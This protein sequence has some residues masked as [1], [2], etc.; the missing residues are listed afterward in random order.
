MGQKRPV[1]IR[2]DNR[3]ITQ[4]EGECNQNLNLNSNKI[5]FAMCIFF[6]VCFL[7]FSRI[8]NTFIFATLQKRKTFYFGVLLLYQPSLIYNFYCLWILRAWSKLH[9]VSISNWMSHLSACRPH[10]CCASMIT[11]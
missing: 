1:N 5:V 10:I 9:E 11:H 8:I 4:E 6:F 2:D 3:K 7:N